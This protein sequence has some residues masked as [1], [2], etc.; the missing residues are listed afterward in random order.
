LQ[1][2]SI[3]LFNYNTNKELKKTSLNSSIGYCAL[4][5]FNGGKK[6]ELY[7]PTE[8]GWL[9]ILDAETLE[10]KDKIFI[11]GEK[12]S[13]VVAVAGKLFV[14]S[15]DRRYSSMEANTLK[16]YDRN[17]K[18]LIRRTGKWANTRLLYLE[19]SDIEL[20]EISENI[21]PID[22]SFHKF[23]SAGLPLEN[24]EDTYHGDHPLDPALARSFPD[25]KKFITSGSGSIYN[26]DLVFEKNLS[27]FN[28]YKYSDFAFNNTGTKIYGA[29]AQEKK[30]EEIEYSSGN[31]TKTYPTTFYPAKVFTDGNQLIC[32]TTSGSNMHNYYFV[33]KINF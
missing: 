6:N 27:E 31:S 4:G 24:K 12:V 5:D 1:S 19:S 2:G 22:L 29:L 20:I 11:G 23:N 18:I 13:S 21:I 25:G 14:S 30:V 8:H 10:T 3:T 28:Y 7:V 32:L 26:R 17:T 15:S 16:V 33:E 9:Y